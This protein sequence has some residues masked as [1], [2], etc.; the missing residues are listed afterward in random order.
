MS[1]LRK[2]PPLSFGG[3]ST[4]LKNTTDGTIPIQG[5]DSQGLCNQFCS[6]R[7]PSFLLDKMWRPEVVTHQ[8]E[9]SSTTLEPFRTIPRSNESLQPTRSTTMRVAQVKRRLFRPDVLLGKSINL[10]L[11]GRRSGIL[12]F[13]TDKSE[14]D[15]ELPTLYSKWKRR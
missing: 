12:Q 3:A 2:I 8:K 5:L 1:N 4:N 6:H 9:Y 7:L 13:A 14:A 15:K 10:R 11:K